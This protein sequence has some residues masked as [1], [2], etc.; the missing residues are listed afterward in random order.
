MRYWI[1]AVAALAAVP[2]AAQPARPAPVDY[3]KESSWLCLPG[4]A[5]VCS[6]PLPTTALNPNGYGSTGKSNIA[7]NPPLDCFYVYPT[8]SRD[9]ALNSDLDMSEE[10]A[11]AASRSSLL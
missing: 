7:A 5:D 3:S 1:A 9:A 4:R 6:T 11:A 2:A 10:L 8:V